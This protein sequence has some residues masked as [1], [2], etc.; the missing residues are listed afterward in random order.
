MPPL[1]VVI[2]GPVLGI[3]VV[4][5]GH[6]GDRLLQVQLLQ[7]LAQLQVLHVILACCQLFHLKKIKKAENSVRYS[8]ANCT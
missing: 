2:V 4:I 8:L 1:Q 7:H 6:A 5:G 3:E